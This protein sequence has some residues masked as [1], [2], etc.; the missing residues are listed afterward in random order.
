MNFKN[1]TILMVIL[2]LSIITV[3]TYGEV[4]KI[5][6]NDLLKQIDRKLNPESFTSYKKII[7][8]DSDGSKKEFVMFIGKRGLDK[9]IGTFLSPKSQVGRSTLRIGDNMWLYIPNLKK[10]IRITSIQSITGG[11]F[12]NSDIMGLDYST[13]YN[14]IKVEEIKGNYKLELKAKSKSVAY[15]KL[16]ILSDKKTLITKEI[17]CFTSSGMLIK[18]LHFKKITKFENGITRPAVVETDSPLHK[19]A[20]SIM[21]Y[22]KMN[23]V[24]LKS[25]LFTI[26]SMSEYKNLR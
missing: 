4:T 20:R 17:K 6:K 2:A 14:C 15:E 8:I 10:P 21:I 25:E 11:L 12:N 22:S 13:E 7:N 3:P 5:D 19:G 23:S 16:T 18:T 9:V 24:E 26:N 1:L